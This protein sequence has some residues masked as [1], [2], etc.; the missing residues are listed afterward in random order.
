MSKHTFTEHLSFRMIPLFF[1]MFSGVFYPP[2]LAIISPPN[3][4][5]VHP[6]ENVTLTVK[7]TPGFLASL[8]PW[9]MPDFYSCHTC[10]DSPLGMSAES[11]P[12]VLPHTFIL[13]IPENQPVGEIVVNV[14]A[15]IKLGERAALRSSGIGLVVV[16][17]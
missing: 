4:A 1:A 17:K 5:I 9:V 7:F 8:F 13:H 6:G 16:A 11:V 3:H 12:S 2:P 10:K 15:S 14:Y